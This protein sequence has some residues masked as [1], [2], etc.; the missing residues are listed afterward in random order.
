[1]RVREGGFS[2]LLL[3]PI[4]PIHNDLAENIIYKTLTMIVM[5][6]AA[7]ALTFIFD[8]N[9]HPTLQNLALFIPALIL[10]FMLRFMVEWTAALAAFWTTR[11]LAINRVYFAV[12]FFLAGRMSPLK[13]L[14]KSLRIASDWLPFRWMIA[15]P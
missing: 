9:I 8:A 3:K 2:P 15:F 5:L 12:S 13:L 1:Y 11:T 6:P 4:H 10:A 7:I 14:P